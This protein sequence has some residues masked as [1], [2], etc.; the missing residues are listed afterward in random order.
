LAARIALANGNPE[1]TRHLVE[2]GL[3][4]VPDD[5]QLHYLTRILEREHPEA[6]RL[7]ANQ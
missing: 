3:R 2:L 4:Y 6:P 5:P 1:K 7:S